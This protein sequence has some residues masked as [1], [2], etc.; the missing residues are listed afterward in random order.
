MPGKQADEK[1]SGLKDLLSDQP[2]FEGGKPSWFELCS[3]TEGNLPEP[4]SNLPFGESMQL[5]LSRLQ[6]LERELRQRERDMELL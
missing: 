4:E 3:W 5:Q 1:C 2:M 6:A